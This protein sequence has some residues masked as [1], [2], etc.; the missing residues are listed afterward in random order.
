MSNSEKLSWSAVRSKGKNRFI[1]SGLGRRGFKVAMPFM[2]GF[3]LMDIN[4]HRITNI[5]SEIAFLLIG[6]VILSVAAGW[7]EGEFVW[8]KLERDYHRPTTG[9][10]RKPAHG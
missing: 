5:G 4:N 9:M 8:H 3:L 10:R 6:Y 1:I 2:I 7:C